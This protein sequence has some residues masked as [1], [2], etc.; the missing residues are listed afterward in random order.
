MKYLKIALLVVLGCTAANS[1]TSSPS[2][3]ILNPLRSQEVIARTENFLFSYNFLRV[4]KCTDSVEDNGFGTCFLD[5]RVPTFGDT[6]FQQVIGDS[7]SFLVNWYDGDF[8]RFP[9]D[10][11]INQIEGIEITITKDQFPI[12]LETAVFLQ[13]YI[14]AVFKERV[15]ELITDISGQPVAFAIVKKLRDGIEIGTRDSGF[16]W[17]HHQSGTEF[18]GLSGIRAIDDAGQILIGQRAL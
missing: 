1:P 9:A 18:F 4:G 7:I 12:K 14:E 5:W 8:D 15:D 10:I 11:R 3:V 17:Q 16:V 6:S 13:D 2:G